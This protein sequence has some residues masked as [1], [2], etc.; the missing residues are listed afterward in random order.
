ML[1][2]I[3]A[4]LLFV[5]LGVGFAQHVPEDSL[6]RMLERAKSYYN[7]GEYENAISELEKALQYLKQMEQGDQ[8]E[9]YKYLAFSY[10]ALGDRE[11]ARETFKKA[12]VLDPTLELDPATVSPKIIKV[13]EEAKAEMATVTP[14]P[15]PKPPTP[16]PAKKEV[17]T[18]SATW[19]SCCL[20]GWGQMHKGESSKG[21]KIMIATAVTF[22][23]AFPS[24]I[25]RELKHTA[26]KDVEP[27]NTEQMNDAY[28]AYKF[29]HNATIYTG[30]LFIGVYLYNLYDVIF[31]KPHSTY[32][33]LELDKGIYC[34]AEKDYIKI[35][36]NLKF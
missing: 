21:K 26:Y 14:K 6:L 25:M 27:G 30:V 24:L 3:I 16:P 17:S 34:I 15:P 1:R 28:K 20:P 2:K 18:L 9:Y 23:L 22:S 5:A 31:T 29:W 32:S 8:V 35:G 7:N 12:L 19:R 11:K 10:V 33:K 13:F 36:Y 4:I